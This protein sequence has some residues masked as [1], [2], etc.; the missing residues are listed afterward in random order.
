MSGRLVRSYGDGR[1]GIGTKAEKKPAHR[2]KDC[3]RPAP[4][5]KAIIQAVVFFPHPY[6]GKNLHRLSERQA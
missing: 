5:V 4:P 3:N 1:E 2:L 6:S